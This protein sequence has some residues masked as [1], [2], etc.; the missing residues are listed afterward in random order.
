MI[1]VSCCGRVLCLSRCPPL[2][3]CVSQVHGA[4][5][6]RRKMMKNSMALPSADVADALSAAGL[7]PE[8]RA[9]DLSLDDFVA[10]HHQLESK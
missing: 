6:H 4:F 10:V 3:G 5:L 1:S 7:N 9:Q 8:S 2:L